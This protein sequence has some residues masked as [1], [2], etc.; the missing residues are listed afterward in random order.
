M[1][2][3]E[4]EHE[5]PFRPRAQCISCELVLVHCGLLLVYFTAISHLSRWRVFEQNI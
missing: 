3:C 5:Y 4:N 1:E 2:I